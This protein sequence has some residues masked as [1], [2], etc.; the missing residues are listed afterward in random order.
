M[1]AIFVPS[2]DHTTPPPP[3]ESI[4]RFASG[5]NH[6]S[7]PPFDDIVSTWLVPSRKRVE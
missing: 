5:T 2:G 4:E 6:V 1:A 7:S 3:R